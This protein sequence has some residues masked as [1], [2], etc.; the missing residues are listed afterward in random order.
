MKINREERCQELEK[1]I[2]VTEKELQQLN[3][4]FDMT[5]QHRYHTKEDLSKIRNLKNS[6]A[7]T[8]ADLSSYKYQYLGI[9]NNIILL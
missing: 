9:K 7:D 6:I 4:E 2:E 3:T 5:L 8:S 1:L